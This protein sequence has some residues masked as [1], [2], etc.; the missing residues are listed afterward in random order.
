MDDFLVEHIRKVYQE[1]ARLELPNI[2]NVSRMKAFVI[3][4]IFD[5]GTVKVVYVFSV[6]DS[7][8]CQGLLHEPIVSGGLS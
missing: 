7:F 3:D 6:A 1:L 4:A 2:R 5:I 8:D